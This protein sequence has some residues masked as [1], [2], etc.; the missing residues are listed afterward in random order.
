MAFLGVGEI[1]AYTI[2]GPIIDKFGR[3]SFIIC[4]FLAAGITQ[5]ILIILLRQDENSP[6]IGPYPK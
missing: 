6:G 1:P 2:T 3:K 4:C 5:I